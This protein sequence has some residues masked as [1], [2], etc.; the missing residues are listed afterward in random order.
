M[1]GAMPEIKS[2]PTPLSTGYTRVAWRT[3]ATMPVDQTRAVALSIIQ[4]TSWR[5]MIV[6]LAMLTGFILVIGG[7]ALG[8]RIRELAFAE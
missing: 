5:M 6:V 1:P 7:R 3:F 4:R 2:A 8:G